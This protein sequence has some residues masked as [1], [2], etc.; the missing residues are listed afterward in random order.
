MAAEAKRTGF[1]SL[2]RFFLLTLS[3]GMALTLIL[4][5]QILP[6]RHEFLEGGVSA[7]TVKSPTRVVFVSEALTVVKQQ[8]AALRV[9]N[10]LVYRPE[11]DREQLGKLRQVYARISQIRDGPGSW[12]E[13]TSALKQIGDIELSPTAIEAVLGLSTADWR[14]VAAPAARL[15]TETMAERV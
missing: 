12:E 1:I 14:A 2:V 7:Q 10:V 8:E 3:M 15:L 9:P 11:I 13:K 5:F 6:S 4:G